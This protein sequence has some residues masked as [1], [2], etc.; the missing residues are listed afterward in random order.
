MTQGYYEILSNRE[1]AKD[2]WEM[3]L[4]GDSSALTNPGQFINIAIEG[5]YL[6]RPIS[7]CH[8]E[9]GSITIIYKVVGKGTTKMTAMQ[10]GK[11]LDVLVG[12]GN[13]FDVSAARGRKA[14]VIGGGV[15]VPPMFNLCKKLIAEGKLGEIV[16][17]RAQLTCWY[18]EM[19]G[20]W[21]QKKA[22]SGGGALIDMG[23][24]CIDL[25]EYITG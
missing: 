8:Y 24:H 11:M 14:A 3:V 4:G 13:G 1:I 23:V 20:A 21:R 6:R 25:I 19:E 15:G 12:L 17:A 16:S 22:L 2:T 7:V 9:E 10:P 18:P 5:L